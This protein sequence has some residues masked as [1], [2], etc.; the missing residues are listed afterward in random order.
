ME[1]RSW[2]GAKWLGI[3]LGMGMLVGACG[4]QSMAQ[5]TATWSTPNA[6]DGI[7]VELPTLHTTPG[8]VLPAVAWQWKS[9]TTMSLRRSSKG[10]LPWNKALVSIAGPI[11][12]TWSTTVSP[13]MVYVAL[14]RHRLTGSQPMTNDM[15]TFCAVNVTYPTNK[16]CTL[17]ANGHL[18]INWTTSI[19]SGEG[20]VVNAGWEPIKPA[21]GAA[22]IDHQATWIASF[23]P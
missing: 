2:I 10:A 15:V 5:S 22:V 1:V 17:E 14:V 23:G 21:R 4:Y 18:R 19:R 7:P 20:L 8:V 12:L 13:N 6:L 3:S 9:R 16:G 11:V